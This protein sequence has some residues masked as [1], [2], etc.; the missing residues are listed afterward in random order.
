[1]HLVVIEHSCEEEKLYIFVFSNK[2]LKIVAC[3]C[4]QPPEDNCKTKTWP[5]I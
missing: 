2:N 5:S 4:L 3:I 1:M